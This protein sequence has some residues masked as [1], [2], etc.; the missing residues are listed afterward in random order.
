LVVLLLLAVAASGGMFVYQATRVRLSSSFAT[1]AVRVAM[2][3]VG[4][5]LLLAAIVL[6]LDPLGVG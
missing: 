5:W 4:A 6:M 2:L 3:G 1:V